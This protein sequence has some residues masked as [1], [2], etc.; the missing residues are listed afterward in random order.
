MG[1]IDKIRKTEKQSR[2]ATRHAVHR[3][4]QMG[5]DAQRRLRQKMRIYPQPVTSSQATPGKSNLK[6]DRTNGLSRAGFEANQRKP[7]VSVHGRDL[8]EDE[9]KQLSEDDN[10]KIA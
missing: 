2:E 9:L 10:E 3:A 6:P 1:L 5:D 7:I 8:S 4:K